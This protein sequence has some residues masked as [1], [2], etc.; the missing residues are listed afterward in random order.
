[1]VSKLITR[2]ELV[3][4]LVIGLAIVTA[5]IVLIRVVWDSGSAN[6]M[7]EAR[8]LLK[9]HGA[10]EYETIVSECKALMDKG[11]ESVYFY[12]EIPK[13]FNS[14]SPNYISAGPSGCE[15]NLYKSPGKGIGYWVSKN[16]GEYTLSWSDHFKS[17]DSYDIDFPA[18]GVNKHRQLDGAKDAPPQL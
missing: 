15:V 2:K 16:N 7:R 12:P 5:P 11:K 8:A 1:M 10:R 4:G 14:V 9:A 18:K 17:W 3:L 6:S 13:V